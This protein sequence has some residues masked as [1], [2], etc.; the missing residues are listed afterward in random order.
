MTDQDWLIELAGGRKP[1]EP[2]SL[3]THDADSCCGKLL[4]RILNGGYTGKSWI[5]PK[6]GE[7]WRAEQVGPVRHWRMYPAFLL[8]RGPRPRVRQ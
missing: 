5:C 3:D 6:C 2:K 7:E 8:M 1:A 4:E